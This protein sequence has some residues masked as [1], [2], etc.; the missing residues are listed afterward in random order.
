MPIFAFMSPL[1]RNISQKKAS[2]SLS[3]VH[4]EPRGLEHFLAAE[5]Y[6][7][8]VLS[9]SPSLLLMTQRRSADRGAHQWSGLQPPASLEVGSRSELTS[10]ISQAEVEGSAQCGPQQLAPRWDMLFGRAPSSR[11]GPSCGCDGAVALLNPGS[12]PLGHEVEITCLQ[13]FT[14]T[15]GR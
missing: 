2:D 12:T 8:A 6:L 14:G 9:L 10:P 7:F 5:K 13:S 15:T 3:C 1:T 11:Q 4:E